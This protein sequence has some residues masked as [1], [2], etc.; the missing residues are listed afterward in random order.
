MGTDDVKIDLLDEEL[1]EKKPSATDGKTNKIGKPMR[2]SL[3]R[4]AGAEDGQEIFHG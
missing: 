4:P 3:A 2:A 1:E